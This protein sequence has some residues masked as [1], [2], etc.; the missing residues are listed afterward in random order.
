VTPAAAP[1]ETVAERKKQSQRKYHLAWFFALAGTGLCAFKRL[2]GREWVLLVLTTLAIY[3]V[4]NV[5]EKILPRLVEALAA[6]WTA[7]RG[8]RS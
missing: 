6:L 8:K 3:S 2:D 4:A 1:Q 7:A 5:S